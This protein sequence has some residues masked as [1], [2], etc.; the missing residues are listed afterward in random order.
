MFKLRRKYKTFVKNTQNKIVFFRSFSHTGF[1]RKTIHPIAVRHIVL[2]RQDVWVYWITNT[3]K[4]MQNFVLTAT[5]N[6][7]AKKY[8][9]FFANSSNVLPSYR[10]IAF[11]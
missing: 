5:N 9:Y 1:H 11:L 7:K 6:T 3:A 4:Y 10:Q 2:L 8:S